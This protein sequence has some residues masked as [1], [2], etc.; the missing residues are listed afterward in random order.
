[1]IGGAMAKK[2]TLSDA[3]GKAAARTIRDD[4]R[5]GQGGM[6]GMRQSFEKSGKKPAPAKD[7]S[8]PDK[9]ADPLDAT[10]KFLEA[11]RNLS[12]AQ[13]EQLDTLRRRPRD[14]SPNRGP[15]FKGA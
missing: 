10:E 3:F 12:D 6:D 1:M 5:D 8:R 14:P 13:K 9:K 11:Q 7:K 15:G 4:D 2:N